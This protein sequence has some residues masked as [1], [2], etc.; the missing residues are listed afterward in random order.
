MMKTAFFKIQ[1][2]CHNSSC[3][4]DSRPRVQRG[5]K[6][7]LK[8][9]LNKLNVDSTSLTDTNLMSHSW[10]I[11]WPS[12]AQTSVFG[13]IGF[14]NAVGNAGA[15]KVCDGQKLPGKGNSKDVPVYAKMV[16]EEVEL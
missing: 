6:N 1:N 14:S 15:Y 9:H 5:V 10:R 11:L 16:L 8:F 3:I 12:W 13:V 2:L 7:Y 4:T